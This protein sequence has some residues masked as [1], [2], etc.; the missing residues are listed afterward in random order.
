MLLLHL[1]LKKHGT[2]YNTQFNKF[3]HSSVECLR[4]NQI[5]YQNMKKAFRKWPNF[6][7]V[8]SMY[9]LPISENTISSTHAIHHYTHSS[10]K[11]RFFREWHTHDINL[12]IHTYIQMCWNIFGRVTSYAKTK[13]TTW[14]RQKMFLTSN[15]K[16]RKIPIV[17]VHVE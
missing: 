2:Q 4:I 3:G 14:A 10:T 8:D 13:M 15:S 17:I 1:V 11:I 16:Y 6:Y 9:Y 7:T 12:H 5:F